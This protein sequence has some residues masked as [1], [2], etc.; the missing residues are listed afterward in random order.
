[1]AGGRERTT[2]GLRLT[3]DVHPESG[4]KGGDGEQRGGRKDVAGIPSG[5]VLWGFL[6]GEQEMGSGEGRIWTTWIEHR[7]FLP[8]R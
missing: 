3:R 4:F 2:A 6:S 7:T 5:L 1:M 8:P